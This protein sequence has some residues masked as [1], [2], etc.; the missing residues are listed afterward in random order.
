[1]LVNYIIRNKYFSL[2]L[3]FLDL[4]FSM[5]LDEMGER[6]NHKNTKINNSNLNGISYDCWIV[7][8]IQECEIGENVFFFFC[9]YFFFLFI[10]KPTGIRSSGMHACVFV[11]MQKNS[12]RSSLFFFL[13][14]LFIRICMCVC[15]CVAFFLFW[16]TKGI[17]K[18]WLLICFTRKWL[19]I[20]L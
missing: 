9:C 10:N 11:L 20:L 16:A 5:D 19:S 14:F 3:S 18:K 2:Y 7:T 8:R 13:S 17:Y 4:S 6:K 12:T 15:V 1:M